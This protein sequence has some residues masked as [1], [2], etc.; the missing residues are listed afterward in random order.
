MSTAGKERK[1]QREHNKSYR[2][3]TRAACASPAST[4]ERWAAKPL[5]LAFS[6]VSGSGSGSE[7]YVAV[8]VVEPLP[9][10]RLP[11]T[12]SATPGPPPLISEITLS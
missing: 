10:G 12:P 5:A 7:E 8:A 9:I 4:E 11:N 1:G 2:T 3:C 6:V